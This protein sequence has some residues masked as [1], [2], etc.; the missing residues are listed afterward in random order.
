MTEACKAGLSEHGVPECVGSETWRQLKEISSIHTYISS[1]KTPL[2]LTPKPWNL[3]F[4]S[5]HTHIHLED[6]GRLK[7]D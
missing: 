2:N 5:T 3:L 6:W 7:P 1:M 4:L